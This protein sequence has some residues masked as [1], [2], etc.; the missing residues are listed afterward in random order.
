MKVSL[1]QTV[2]AIAGAGVLAIYGCGGGGGGGGGGDSVSPPTSLTEAVSLPSNLLTQPASS[3]CAAMR[4][5]TYVQLLL[6]ADSPNFPDKISK[7]SIDAVAMTFLDGSNNVVGTLSASSE[8]CRFTTSSGTDFV[9]SQAGVSVMR[10]DHT[11]TKYL[12]ISLPEQHFTLADM[13]GTWNL[14]G[15]D[16]TNPGTYDGYAMTATFNSTGVITAA[17][18][19]R[20]AV[21]WDVTTCTD[22]T[23]KMPTLRANSDGGFDVLDS[24]NTVMGRMFAYKAGSGDVMG[25]AVSSIGTFELFTKQ[26]TNSLPTV[27]AVSTNWNLAMGSL[28]TSPDV[29]MAFSNTVMSTDSVAGSWVRNQ[30]TMGGNDAHSETLFANNPRNGY[31]FRPAGTA[32]AG[33]GSTV[34]FGEFTS[35]R[36]RGMGVSASLHPAQKRFSFSVDQP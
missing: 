23:S 2:L 28:L 27:G 17:S 24:T 19:C 9:V 25:V 3:S 33:D 12:G 8:P 22:V 13:A 34:T 4:S 10:F 29:P 21:T 31:T 7:N 35:L 16:S 5:G 32:M 36:L 11:A 26:R 20:N 18:R 1:K 6:V 30:K 15:M 14:L